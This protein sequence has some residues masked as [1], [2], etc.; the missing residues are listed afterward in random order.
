MPLL[1]VVLLA[2]AVAAADAVSPEP[3]QV[4]TN[5][6]PA[7]DGQAPYVV[8][9]AFHQSNQWCSGT[10]IGDTWILTAR[11]CLTG[12]TGVTIYFGATR[13]SQALLAMYVGS[14]QYIQDNEHLAL[15]RVPKVSFGNRIRKVA[16]P[17]LRNQSNRYENRWATT[18]GWGSS[19]STRTQPDWLQCVDLQI[20]SNTECI[21]FYGLATITDRILCTRTTNGKSICFGDAGSPL[22]I[23][24]GSTMVGLSL[25]VSTQGCTLGL[26]AGFSRIT[27]QLNW[28]RQHTGIY[29]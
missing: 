1:V 15:V 26:P 25:F 8:G 17:G 28:I 19:A 20:M 18:C 3:D 6:S 12:S 14:T 29:Y 5:G 11:A 2:L 13:R 22:V 10:I 4:I 16:L 21:P 27:S 9:M 23:A 7:Y 24:Q